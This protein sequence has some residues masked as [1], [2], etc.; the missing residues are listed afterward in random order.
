MSETDGPARVPPLAPPER[1]ERQAALVA[2]AGG[3]LG[4]Y[5][6]LVRSPDV[7]ADFLTFGQRLLNLSTLD[8]GVR[9]LFILRVAWRCRARYIWSHHEEIGRSAGLTDA[10]LEALTRDTVEDDGT[11][12]ALALRVADE[13]VVEHRLSDSTWRDLAARYPTDQVIEVCMLVGS[14]AMLAG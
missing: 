6:T 3:E 1:D 2:R 14:Y 12:R 11:P 5:T 10:D 9:E 13:L 8:A 4:V 7:F